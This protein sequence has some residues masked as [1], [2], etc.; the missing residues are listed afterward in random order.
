MHVF[1]DPADLV[2][3]QVVCD[4]VL[5]TAEEAALHDLLLKQLAEKDPQFY[6]SAASESAG[7]AKTAAPGAVRD[8][9]FLDM[10]TCY[11]QL[12]SQHIQQLKAYSSSGIP[13]IGMPA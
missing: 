7:Q 3:P 13:H 6:G 5:S 8:L 10:D 2:W 1:A 4:F 11:W 9:S 12:A